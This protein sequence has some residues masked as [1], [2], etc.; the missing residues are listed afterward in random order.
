MRISRRKPYL[1]KSAVPV[2]SQPAD[3]FE[4]ILQQSDIS[5]IASYASRKFCFCPHTGRRPKRTLFDNT[6][7]QCSKGMCG[8][9][10]LRL[11]RTGNQGHVSQL[12]PSFISYSA[13]AFF[14]H[15][16]GIV[17]FRTACPGKQVVQ[18][19]CQQSFEG[20]AFEI[21]IPL[22]IDGRIDV[23]SAG[24]A[25][26]G[27]KDRIRFQFHFNYK[28]YSLAHRH[29]SSQNVQWSAISIGSNSKQISSLST[30][31]KISFCI[32][33]PSTNTRRYS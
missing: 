27:T 3:T 6:V 7:F 1:A 11:N 2:A 29:P 21:R 15:Q 32:S 26:A 18:A 20:R 5:L 33:A 13:P 8:K 4:S 31:R 10:F 28:G 17:L 22:F 30:F 19:F 25:V 23:I 12:Q 16:C 24:N 14:T 9:C